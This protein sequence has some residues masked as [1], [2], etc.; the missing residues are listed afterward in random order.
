M[1]TMRALGAVKGSSVVP[2]GVRMAVTLKQHV[3]KRSLER[4][5]TGTSASTIGL[6]VGDLD[7]FYMTMPRVAMHAAM[8][9]CVAMRDC[10]AYYIYVCA[11]HV[12]IH[13]PYV[14]MY[15]A[16]RI[17]IRATVCV[18][19]PMH[20]AMHVCH[21]HAHRHAWCMYGHDRASHETSCRKSHRRHQC[22]F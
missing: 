1:C 3:L 13:M 21:V 22:R 17:A 18:V 2:R 5:T 20:V 6:V 9:L 16:M 7:L 11:M 12:G 10:P 19:M 14:A 15:V 8:H 4:A